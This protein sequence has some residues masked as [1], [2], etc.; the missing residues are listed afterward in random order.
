MRGVSII[1][2]VAFTTG[3]QRELPEPPREVRAGVPERYQYLYWSGVPVAEVEQVRSRLPYSRIELERMPCYGHC[4]SY[5]LVLHRDGSAEYVGRSDVTRQGKYVGEVSIFD[6]GNLC[7]LLDR[8]SLARF[9]REY[10]A[11][12]TD[13]DTAIVR[14]YPEGADS[15]I[16]V[17]DY[18][19]YGPNELWTIQM[20]IDAVGERVEWEKAVEVSE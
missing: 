5:I 9:Q 4:P 6:Y 11:P 13:A 18:G 19:R 17:S 10:N 20:S 3:C 15:P 16:E 1:L 2:L 7:Y 12:W 8:T 14:V